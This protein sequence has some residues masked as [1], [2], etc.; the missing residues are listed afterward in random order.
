MAKI[1]ERGF[2][3][4][5]TG[6]S[7][8]KDLI[9]P[10]KALCD[11]LVE[12][13]IAGAKQKSDELKEFKKE[14]SQQIDSFF[15]LLLQNYGIDPKNKSKKGNLALENF[16][17]TAKIQLSVAETLTFDEK[18]QIAK[19]KLDE[20]LNDITKNADPVIR[21]LIT[22]AFEV[23]K[24]GNIDSKK[25]FALKSYDIKDPRWLEAMDI[26]EESKTVSSIK[27]YIRFYTRNSI[28]NEYAMISL[29]I[30][31]I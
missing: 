20:Y 17:G 14:T 19:I 26:I 15:E 6:K 5:K 30:A 8:H 31:S 3:I 11:E 1:D 16:S 4:D 24:K 21:T 12:R 27:P 10:D 9:T 13:I 28:E 22:K 23:D 29:D 7:V 18:L 2:W 25:I